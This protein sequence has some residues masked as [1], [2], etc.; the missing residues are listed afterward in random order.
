MNSIFLTQNMDQW[1]AVVDTKLRPVHSK[2]S[3]EEI[4][5]RHFRPFTESECSH[6]LHVM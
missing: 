5:L 3:K 6:F 2:L 1:R 4:F